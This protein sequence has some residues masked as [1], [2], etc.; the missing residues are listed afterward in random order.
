MATVYEVVKRYKNMELIKHII[1]KDE[2]EMAINARNLGNDLIK[3]A[4]LIESE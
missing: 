2:K 3:L 4:D 1:S